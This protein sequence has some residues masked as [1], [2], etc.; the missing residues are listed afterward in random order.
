[1]SYKHHL[2]EW[3]DLVTTHEA[4]RAGFIAIALE[5]NVKASPIID[6][7]KSL[8]AYA[9]RAKTPDDLSKMSDIY[10]ALLTAAGLSDK[11][12]NHLTDE[13]KK[14][15]INEL[16]KKFLEPAGNNFVDELVYRFLLTKGD[17]LGGMMR[18][19]AGI[20]GEKKFIRG[21][22]S[23]LALKNIPFY[24]IPKKKARDWIEGEYNDSTLEGNVRALSWKN[25]IGYR[26]I[27][28]NTTP[29]TVKK[30]VDVVIL[31]S[32]YKNFNKET[33]KDHTKYLAL[34]ELKCG[35]DPAGADEH[36]KTANTALTRIRNS[37]NQLGTK[38]KTF[39]IGAAIENSMAKEIYD[40]LEQG[41]LTNA[42][43][44]TK[45]DQLKSICHW[46][47]EI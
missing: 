19:L 23:S 40:Q 28:L 35:F 41:I 13:D 38:P 6:E 9:M 15:A 34:G 11:S 14:M 26:V 31:K 39:F 4:T 29:P 43:N 18:N 7:A 47:C 25:R 3:K 30:N 1:M 45:E 12:L 42:A 8:K 16:I 5:K 2:K 21:I 44:S 46:I 10:P 17:A 33:I 36:W 24:Y 20:I 37:F 27:L 22:I 32:S